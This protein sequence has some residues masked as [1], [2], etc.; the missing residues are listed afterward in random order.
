[1]SGSCKKADRN[2]KSAAN[3]A[4]KN[5]SRADINKAKRAKREKKRAEAFATRAKR[6]AAAGKPA[7]GSARRRARAHLQRVAA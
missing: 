7:R 5:S 3:T 1:M 6:R 2:R 4:Y